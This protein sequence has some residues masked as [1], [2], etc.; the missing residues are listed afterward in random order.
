MTKM[1]GKKLYKS[2]FCCFY[3]VT[4][5]ASSFNRTEILPFKTAILPS[6]SF[7]TTVLCQDMYLGL[8]TAICYVVTTVITFSR[9]EILQRVLD[10]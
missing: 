8:F 10:V 4:E 1:K 3:A 5:K 6:G 2:Q 9:L 7:M